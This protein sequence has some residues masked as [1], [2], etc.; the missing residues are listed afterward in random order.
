MEQLAPEHQ[1]LKATVLRQN[2]KHGVFDDVLTEETAA[3]PL[4]Q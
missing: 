1:Q 3:R 4:L 2:T